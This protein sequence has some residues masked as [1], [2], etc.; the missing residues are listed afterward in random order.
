MTIPIV[1]VW[2]S[3]THK[4]SDSHEYSWIGTLDC[5]LTDELWCVQMITRSVRF[6][7]LSMVLWRI[8]KCY[9]VLNV[10]S[11]CKIK[12]IG[13]RTNCVNMCVLSSLLHDVSFGVIVKY[14]QKVSRIQ[15]SQAYL[16]IAWT[17]NSACH[18]IFV[19][20]INVNDQ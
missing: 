14:S 2:Q 7:M 8:V 16:Q 3:C 10:S 12:L 13:N 9:S 17:W 11:D 6:G 5:L 1:Y 19:L 20:F 18:S 15:G 4:W